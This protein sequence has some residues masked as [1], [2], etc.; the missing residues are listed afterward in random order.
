MVLVRKRSLT[1]ICFKKGT[2]VIDKRL[3]KTDINEIS[4]T[5]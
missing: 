3:E 4:R 1:L 5:L 2:V